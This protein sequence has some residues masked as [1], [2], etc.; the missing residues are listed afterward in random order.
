MKP[1][2]VSSRA[3]WHSDTQ[4]ASISLMINALEEPVNGYGIIACLKALT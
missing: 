1:A 2:L 3:L 4:N